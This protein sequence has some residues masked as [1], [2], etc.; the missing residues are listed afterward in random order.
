[1]VVAVAASLDR[2]VGRLEQG[3]GGLL[4]AAL[5]QHEL[6]QCLVFAPYLAVRRD[7]RRPGRSLL[8]LV[9]RLEQA[10][11]LQHGRRGFGALVAGLAAGTV[12]GLLHGLGGE[13][14]E[15]D[16]DAG[17]T[18]DRA[19]AARG[20][21]GDVVEVGGLAPITVPRATMPA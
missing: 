21:T 7:V 6:E 14:A 4:E 18:G 20:L 3:Q 11:H 10:G 12:D 16:G 13:H 8:A 9:D 15:A 17:L 5:G 1:M 2:Q 19:E